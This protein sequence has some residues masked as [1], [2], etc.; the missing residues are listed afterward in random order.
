MEIFRVG[1]RVT[2]INAGSSSLE[3]G[4]I[5]TIT[6]VE[7]TSAKIRVND[8]SAYGNWVNFKDLKLVATDSERIQA[9][10]KEMAAVR[11][12]IGKYYKVPMEVE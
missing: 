1:D 9:L 4:D 5:G 10:E 12:F 3:N 6:I 8:K 11:E 7:G 2:V